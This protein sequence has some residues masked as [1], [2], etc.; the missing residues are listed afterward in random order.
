M[1][2]IDQSMLLV[3]LIDLR[4]TSTHIGM[5]P[6]IFDVQYKWQSTPQD[7]PI[8]PSFYTTMRVVASLDAYSTPIDILSCCSQNC[9]VGH[10]IAPVM[11]VINPNSI[12]PSDQ[13]PTMNL[14]MH[15]MHGLATNQYCIELSQDLVLYPVV[16]FSVKFHH[17]MKDAN[18]LASNKQKFVSCRVKTFHTVQLQRQNSQSLI[19]MVECRLHESSTECHWEVD[20]LQVPTIDVHN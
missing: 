16:H 5:L 14:M 4:L 18:T 20:D 8:L 3:V 6:Q 9:F 7:C 2:S 10:Q 19:K 15:L 11:I 17:H 13:C 1:K 12:V